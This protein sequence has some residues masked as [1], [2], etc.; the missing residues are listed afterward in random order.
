MSFAR[1]LTGWSHGGQRMGFEKRPVQG[2]FEFKPA[3]HEPGPKTV[4]G[5]TYADAGEVQAR[6]ILSDLVRHPATARHIAT[7]LVRHFVADAP[8]ADAVDRI[9]A[10]FTETDGDLAEVTRA[11]VGLDAAW[12]MPLA[13]AKSHY[14]FVIGVHRALGGR[15]LR[16]QDIVQPLR[17]MGQMPFGAPS[18]AGWGDRAPDW[19]AP[20]ALM[21]RIEW[22]RRLTASR[23]VP[24]PPL[25]M[26]DDIVGPVAG[27]AL[28]L[29]VSRAATPQDALTMILASPEFQRR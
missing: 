11:V 6:A 14:D 13:K 5:K 7:K 16:R 24:K 28:R 4:L 29:E 25:H 21:R 18:P 23:R 27:A 20:E 12:A 22:L 1:A 15:N 8:P 19:I 26:L 10:V 3:F 2:G 9:A 17:E